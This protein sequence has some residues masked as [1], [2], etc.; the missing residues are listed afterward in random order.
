M[1]FLRPALKD[2]NTLCHGTNGFIPLVTLR[3]TYNKVRID[4]HLLIINKNSLK[5]GDALKPLLFNFNH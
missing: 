3:E 2:Q 5:Q 1:L 4:K